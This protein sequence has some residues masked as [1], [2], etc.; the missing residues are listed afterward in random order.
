[1]PNSR[2]RF[3]TSGSGR[4]GASNPSVAVILNLS[5]DQLARTG[6]LVVLAGEGADELF[7]GYDRY[8]PHPRVA[9][10]DRLPSPG[11]R[12]IAS[13]LW[14]LMPHGARGKNFLRHVARDDNG[15]YRGCCSACDIHAAEIVLGPAAQDGLLVRPAG[16]VLAHPLGERHHL[17]VRPHP[18]GPSLEPGEQLLRVRRLGFRPDSVTFLSAPGRIEVVARGLDV[19]FMTGLPRAKPAARQARSCSPC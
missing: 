18:R 9:Q 14:P 5:R 7:G 16:V 4:A 3:R 13:A 11:S 19:G 2:A 1:M 17:P 12:R 8:I 6:C 15:R 10:F